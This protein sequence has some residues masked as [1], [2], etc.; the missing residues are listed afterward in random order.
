[1]ATYGL[2]YGYHGKCVGNGEIRVTNGVSHVMND[3][4]DFVRKQ[5]L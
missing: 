1:M 4:H 5:D 3:G 2:K